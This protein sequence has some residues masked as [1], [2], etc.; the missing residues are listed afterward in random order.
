MKA[1][2]DAQPH[3]CATTV[4]GTP[5]GTYIARVMGMIHEPA[6]VASRYVP[7]RK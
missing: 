2:A 1:L 4:T 7:G 3:W 6:R 5:L